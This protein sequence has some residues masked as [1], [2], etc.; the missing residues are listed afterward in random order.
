MNRITRRQFL[1]TTAAVGMM[2]AAVA[3]NAATA[4]A[5][6][7]PVEET[8]CTQT[9]VIEGYDWGPGVNATILKLGH[10]V[11]A[12]SV[13]ADDFVS[14]VETKESMNYADSAGTHITASAQRTVLDAYTCSRDGERVNM[15]SSYIRIDL[16]CD[17]NSGSPFCGDSSGK[18]NWCDPYELDITL[19]KDSALTT[20]LG[21]RVKTMTID[22]TVDLNNALIP[23]MDK[24]VLDGT[25]AASDGKNLT[26][27]YYAPK[28]DKLPL[29]I[30]VHGAGEGGTDPSIA[31][32]GNKVTELVT[33]EFQQAMGGAA[34]VLVPQTPTFWLQYN[35]QGDWQ[36]NP[37]VP[38]VYTTA[39]KELIDA[40]VAEHPAVDKDRIIIGGCSNGGYM[41][42]NMVMQYPDY[43][44][45]AYPICEAYKDSGITDEQLASVK[46]LPLWFVYAE[47]DPIVD[48]TV[49]EA[50]TIARL[51][52]MGANVHTSI[53]A[54]VHDTTG[55]YKGADGAPYQYMGHWSWLYFFNNKCADDATG[56]NMWSWM[57][58]QSK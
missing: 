19:K 25:F 33:D 57:G 37:G 44:A 18:N 52:A 54:D 40:F 29:V 50:P 4:S 38:S 21:Q 42:M 10:V 34:Y 39:L 47:N 49:Y 55:L 23:Q 5:C 26:Y 28:G 9:A 35:E 17:P 6:L 46:N 12:D 48:P 58:K 13:S 45:A 41:T 3:G 24:F 1:R 51:K 2:G 7:A 53:Y 16:A 11:R 20:L 36:N 32:L 30:W 14:V 22:C 56:E 31:V 15:P 27:G 8:G 43:F